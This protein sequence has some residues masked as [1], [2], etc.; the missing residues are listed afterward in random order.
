VA[1][2]TADQLYA[3]AA[4]SESRAAVML[5]HFSDDDAPPAKTVKLDLSGF[6]A[7]NGVKIS[8]S[9]LDATHDADLVREEIFTGESFSAILELPLF[10]VSLVELEAL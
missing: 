6:S 3:A 8:Y 5:A 4:K 2:E 1:V 10:G 9:L 7:P